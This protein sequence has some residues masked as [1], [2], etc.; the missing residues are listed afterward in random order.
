[1]LAGL[2]TRD[3]RNVHSARRVSKENQKAGDAARPRKE[4]LAFFDNRVKMR[5]LL[6]KK[7]RYATVYCRTSAGT[8][9]D[10]NS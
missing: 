6:S 7:Y 8:R 9:T 4:K 10:R 2:Q 1:M 5:M 3:L